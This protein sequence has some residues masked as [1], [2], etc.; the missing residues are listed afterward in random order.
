MVGGPWVHGPP[1]STQDVIGLCDGDAP[2]GQALLRFLK[3][4]GAHGYTA[5][6]PGLGVCDRTAHRYGH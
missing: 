3:G 1:T 5:D 4:I 6:P 2:Q